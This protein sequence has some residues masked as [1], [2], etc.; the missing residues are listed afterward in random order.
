M[1]YLLKFLSVLIIFTSCT[2]AVV[3]KMADADSLVIEF[4]DV[5]NKTVLKTVSTNNKA[6]IHKIIGFVDAAADEH[7]KCGYDGKLI[8]FMQGQAIQYIDFM[9]KDA[10]CRH[11]SFLLDDKL[12]STK[13][14][15]EAADF[16]ESLEQGKNYY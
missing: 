3:N 4:K 12:M 5:I 9:R 7:Y 1:Q 2:S 11:F 14:N 8:F 6:A 10:H 13:M 15:N 16:L